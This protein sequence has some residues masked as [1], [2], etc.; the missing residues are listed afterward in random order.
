MQIS[1]ELTQCTFQAFDGLAPEQIEF[2]AS[3]WRKCGRELV[4]ERALNAFS[5]PSG[6]QK[7]PR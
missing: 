6:L 1:A 2:V 4:K 3:N 7:D 5:G